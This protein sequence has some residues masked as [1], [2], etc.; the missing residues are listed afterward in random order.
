MRG[1]V[2]L[3]NLVRLGAVLA[4]FLCASLPVGATTRPLVFPL[5]FTSEGYIHT[6]FT[7]NDSLELPAIIDT[8]A[9]IA[10]I[11]GSAASRAGIDAPATDEARLPVYGLL[12][13]REFPVISINT[14]SSESVRIFQVGAAY[15]DRERMPGGQL[16]IPATAFGGDVLD[17][18][19]PA[20][21]LY[22]YNGRPQSNGRSSGKGRLTVEGG[23]MFA[24]VAVNGVK[25]KALIDTGSPFSFINSNMA[26][27]AKARPDEERTRSLQGA[28]GGTLSVSVASVK[29]LS[30]ARFNINRLNMIVAD[31]AMFKD[32]G[33]QDEPAMLLGLDLLSQFRVQIDRKRGYLILIPADEGQFM[34]VNF[35]ARGTRISQ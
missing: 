34:T 35:G 7:V 25:G 10:M 31:P 3:D 19:F 11:D 1:L 33:L 22:V 32:L 21:R 30:V 13:L 2:L 24:E 8:A 5:T 20:G 12:G 29:R 4:A 14:L 26:L 27:A 17:F 6:A 15:N 23:L 18:D 28:T 9:T 16:V